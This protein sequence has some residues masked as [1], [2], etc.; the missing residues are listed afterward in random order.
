MMANCVLG[1]QEQTQRTN[2]PVLT[3]FL[4]EIQGGNFTAIINTTYYIVPPSPSYHAL[5]KSEIT[6]VPDTE[7]III[8][9]PYLI[10]DLREKL[11]GNVIAGLAP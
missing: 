3:A 11:D 9:L 6:I 5:K 2:I 8:S 10:W 7:T 4:P 1:F